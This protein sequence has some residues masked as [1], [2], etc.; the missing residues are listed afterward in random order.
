MLKLTK[1]ILLSLLFAF[2]AQA[3][4]LKIAW[5]DNATN[6]TFFMV[7][8]AATCAGPWTV[9]TSTLPVNTLTYT[10]ATLADAQPVAYRI[11][12]GNTAGIGK[13]PCVSGTAS[14]G[15]TVNKTG[16]GSGTVTSS[17]VGIDCG[18]VCSG[19]VPGNSVIVLTPAPATGSV[20]AGWSGACTGTGACSITMNGAKTVTANFNLV[21]A[22]P[23]VVNI[24]GQCSVP[25]DNCVIKITPV[26]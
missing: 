11:G 15:L 18:A 19:R 22:N 4:S 21:P 9:L 17:P 5:Q 14:A 26:P 25:S 1:L 7:E 2:N 12:A 24:S 10:D 6:E 8:R 23:T 20:F 13:S 16:T 3:A